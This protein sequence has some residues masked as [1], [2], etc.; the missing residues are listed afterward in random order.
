MESWPP[1]APQAQPSHGHPLRGLVNICP[2][3]QFIAF[4]P[5]ALLVSPPDSEVR[6]NITSPVCSAPNLS[7][8]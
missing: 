6:A 4:N 1:G 3:P 8:G 2:Q 7:P 5:S